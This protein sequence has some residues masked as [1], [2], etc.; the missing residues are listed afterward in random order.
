MFGMIGGCPSVP[1]SSGSY[2]DYKYADYDRYTGGQKAPIIFLDDLDVDEAA[3]EICSYFA[4]YDAG[5]TA[6]IREQANLMI[7]AWYRQITADLDVIVKDES[8]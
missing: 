6:A 8:T 7:Q 3:D 5:R 4:G 2:Y 1:L